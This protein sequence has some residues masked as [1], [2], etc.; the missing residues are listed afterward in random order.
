MLAFEETKYNRTERRTYTLWATPSILSFSLSIERDENMIHHHVCSSHEPSAC[1]YHKGPNDVNL[2]VLSVTII[3]YK[4]PLGCT[5]YD[6]RYQVTLRTTLV[7]EAS[8]R[9]LATVKQVFCLPLPLRKRCNRVDRVLVLGC[10]GQYQ[11]KMSSCMHM[12]VVSEI[13]KCFLLKC[14]NRKSP[15]SGGQGRKSSGTEWFKFNNSLGCLR[16]AGL[17]LVLPLLHSLILIPGLAW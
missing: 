9:D 7:W 8:V 10:Y 17:S 15:W 1:L 4:R 16:G 5:I 12:C 3:V 6:S 11:R 2:K 13:L 14:F